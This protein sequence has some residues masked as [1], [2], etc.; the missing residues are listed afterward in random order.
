[1]RWMRMRPESFGELDQGVVGDAQPAA[2]AEA[3][4]T[5]TTTTTA[6]GADEKAKDEQDVTMSPSTLHGVTPDGRSMATGRPIAGRATS[7][8]VAA[9][10]G[11]I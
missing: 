11:A 8:T 2:S 1:M 9:T 7:T 10:P 4:S 6:A 5:T 3:A